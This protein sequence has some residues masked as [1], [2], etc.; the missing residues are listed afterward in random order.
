MPFTDAFLSLPTSVVSWVVGF[1]AL[2]VAMYFARTS[3]H[4]MLITATRGLYKAMRLSAAAILK[5]ENRQRVSLSKFISS[6]F[7]RA[8][9]A[10]YEF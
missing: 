5:A 6:G 9:G 3:A 1:I 10:R 2:V 4:H 8:I 7:A